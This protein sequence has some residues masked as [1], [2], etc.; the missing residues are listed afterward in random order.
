LAEVDG[1]G[2]LS[3]P[4]VCCGTATSRTGQT[5]ASALLVAAGLLQAGVPIGTCILLSLLGAMASFYLL[6]TYF[7]AIEPMAC[8]GVLSADPLMAA[9]RRLAARAHIGSDVIDLSV[10]QG[11]V[12]ANAV[13]EAG[14]EPGELIWSTTYPF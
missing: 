1:I 8:A 3:V 6:R 5:G 4:D 9:M 14:R 7:A 12:Q 13:R 11:V 2:V 10:A